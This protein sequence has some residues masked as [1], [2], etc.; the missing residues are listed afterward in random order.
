MTVRT[1]KLLGRS[2][3]DEGPVSLDVAWNGVDVFSGSVLTHLNDQKPYD[4]LSSRDFLCEWTFPID[5]YGDMPIRISVTGGELWWQSVWTNYVCLDHRYQLKLQTTWLKY[6]PQSGQEV[7]D[8]YEAL[9]DEEFVDKYGAGAVDNI[10]SIVVTPAAQFF[11]GTISVL[12]NQTVDNDGK[13]NVRIN[14]VAQHMD[15]ALRSQ[16][17]LGDW[18]WRINSGQVIEADVTIDAPLLD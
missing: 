12:G 9:T 10:E 4:S 13:N 7:M 2:Y 11:M 14:G 16:G 3:S 5:V 1:A 17:L 6:Q 8:D 15:M 18:V